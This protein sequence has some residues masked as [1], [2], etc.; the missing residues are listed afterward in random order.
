MKDKNGLEKE[1]NL[2]QFMNREMEIILRALH[3]KQTD[4]KICNV[5]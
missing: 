4:N 1:I 2:N 5:S 3:Q